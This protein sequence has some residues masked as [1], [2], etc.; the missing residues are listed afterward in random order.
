MAS[1]CQTF[2][3]RNRYQNI[4]VNTENFSNG[5][6]FVRIILKNGKQWTEKLMINNTFN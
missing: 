5:I 4:T 3:T 6:Y 1:K 2:H